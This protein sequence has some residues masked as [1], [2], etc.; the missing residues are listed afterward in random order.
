MDIGLTR[1]SKWLP[2]RVHILASL[3]LDGPG[4]EEKGPH[5]ALSFFSDCPRAWRKAKACLKTV[6]LRKSTACFLVTLEV[7][8][9]HWRCTWLLDV[10]AA[11]LAATQLAPHCPESGWWQVSARLCH[12]SFVAITS[13]KIEQFS[14]I[15][16]GES[17]IC[18]PDVSYYLSSLL[19]TTCICLDYKLLLFFRK[20]K[21]FV[22]QCGFYF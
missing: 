11:V 8:L 21:Y 20:K 7:R 15:D 3:E 5:F 22:D 14:Q 4:V 18:F 9:L 1:V 17:P 12:N 16:R 13:N 6:L 10:L 2:S 19:S